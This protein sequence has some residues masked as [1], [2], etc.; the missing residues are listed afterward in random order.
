MTIYLESF[1][2]QNLLINLS[3]LRLVSLTTKT[4]TSLFKLILSSIVGIIPSLLAAFILE[5]LFIINIMKLITSFIMIYAA[6]KQNIKQF[7]F[8]VILLFI[9]TYAMGGIIISFTSTTYLTQFGFVTTSKISL[10][11]IYLIILFSSYIFEIILKNLYLKIKTNGLIYNLTLTQSTQS[12]KIK[13]YL[14]TGNFLNHNGKPVLILDLN[15]Y[16]KLTNNNLINFYSTKFDEI[17]TKTI[18]GN[19]KIRILTIDKMEI[20]NKNKKILLKNQIIAINTNNCFK[21]SN[22]QALLSPLF[23]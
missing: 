8:N 13:A 4:N 20:K 11:L 14:D 9:Y 1:I 2:L 3:L 16:L 12:I 22:Y 7:I 18:N 6:F 15:S 23:L 5:N 17:S 21:N 19:K 10:E